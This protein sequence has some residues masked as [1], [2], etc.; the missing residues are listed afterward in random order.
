MRPLTIQPATDADIPII[1]DILLDVVAWL[2]AHDLHLWER[3]HV[4]WPELGKHYPIGTFHIACLDGVPVGCMALLDHD[5]LFWPDV[6]AGRSL[7]IH[8]LAVKRAA[9]GQGVSQALIAHAK[10]QCAQRG[11]GELRLD[12]HQHRNK[13]RALYEAQGFVCVA[14]KRMFGQFDVAFYLCRL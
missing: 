10:A 5:P 11:I 9:A 2:D 13:L 6:P 8:K 12:C 1:E 3:Q 14:E 7:Y 4:T